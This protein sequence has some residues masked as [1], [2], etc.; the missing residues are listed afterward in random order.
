MPES[1]MLKTLI[2]KLVAKNLLQNNQQDKIIQTIISKQQQVKTP[3]FINLLIGCG[4]WLATILL[5]VFLFAVELIDSPT[6][7]LAMGVIFIIGTIALQHTKI[8]NIFYEQFILAI[9]L[10]GQVLFIV[11]MV[12]DTNSLTMGAMATCCLEIVVIVV[13]PNYVLRFFAVLIATLSILILFY[14]IGFYQG[15][16]ILVILMATTTIWIWLAES[17]HITNKIMLNLYEPLGYGFI[18]ALQLILL[19]SILPYNDFIPPLTW[20]YSTFGLGVVLLA[21]EVHILSINQVSPSSSKGIAILLASLLPIILLYNSPGI[22]AAIIVL[23][24]GFQRGNRVLMG[25]GV[26]C[27]ILFF[28][29]FYYYLNISLLMKSISLISAG[30]ILLVFRFVFLSI[31]PLQTEAKLIITKKLKK[32]I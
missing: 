28:I 6:E 22:I 20:M 19:I 23:L 1:I 16:H 32:K 24:L 2:E 18:T 31:F 25:L 9:H 29:A 27:L 4:A 15:V 8:N 12:N 11:G 17:N 7:G 3:W 5:L 10:V 14:D 30:I 13:Y 26:V 21:L